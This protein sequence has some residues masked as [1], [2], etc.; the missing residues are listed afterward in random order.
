[1]MEFVI[2]GRTELYV[3]GQPV[4]LGAARQRGLLAV[5][6]YHVGEGVGADA[7]V[8]YLWPGRPGADYRRQLY[9]L[10]SRARSVLAGVGL[11]D[12]LNRASSGHG[13]R[14]VVDPE[15]IDYHRFRN[16]VG[17][18]RHAA[19]RRS[20]ELAADRLTAAVDLWRDE[21]L[22]DLDGPRVEHLRRHMRLLH[23]DAVRMLADYQLR[24]GRHEAVLA[25]LEPLVGEDTMDEALAQYWIEAQCASGRYD[26]ARSFFT[27]FRDR[28][29]RQ[30]RVD[31]AV[32]LPTA[33]RAG[34]RSEA[35]GSARGNAGG[36]RLLPADINDFT[37]HS[38]TLDILDRLTDPSGQRS[39]VVAVCGMPG[40]GKTT[41]AI[42]W[43]H[44][45][46]RRFPDGQIY[47]DARGYGPTRAA[48]PDEILGRLLEALGL[49]ADRSPTNPERRRERLSRLLTGRRALI[50][51]D[52]V[53]NSAHAEALLTTADTCVTLVT[54]RSRL[55][56]LS[57]QR[58]VRNLVI[59]PLSEDDALAFLAQLV[60]TPRAH[61]EPDAMRALAR[62]AAGLPLALRIIGEH[63][64]ERP[65]ARLADL[66]HELSTRLLADTADEELNLRSV[67]GWSY[68]RLD[69]RTAQAFRIIGLH[70][71]ATITPE[72]AAA[73]S[74]IPA[75]ECEQLLDQLARAHLINHD[76]AGRYRPHDLL[77]R[78]ATDRG[79]RQDRVE[80]RRAATDR[81][82]DWYLLSAANAATTLAAHAEPV[83]DLPSPGD[84]TPLTF[85]SSLDATR[86]AEAEREN[87]AAVTRWA[88][89]HDHHRHAWQ[90]PGVIHQILDPSGRMDDIVELN[91]IALT[92]VRADR[93]ESGEIGILNNLG[94][95]YF[96][97][98]DYDRASHYFE[99][100]LALARHSGL[101]DA[102]TVYAYNLASAHFKLGQTDT[103]LSEYMRVLR[104][105]RKVSDPAGEAATLHRLG[106]VHRRTGAVHTAIDYYGQALTIRKRLGLPRETAA[107][108][109]AL[110]AAYLQAG[111]TARAETYGQ[112]ALEL[113]VTTRDEPA[114]CDML[115]TMA[116]VRRQ[117][118]ITVQALQDARRALALADGLADSLRQGT[119]GTA[120]AG[121]L[122]AAGDT[123]AARAACR[124]AL[125]IL[126]DVIDPDARVPYQ[127]L[128]ELHRTLSGES[129]TSG[130][131]RNANGSS[132]LQQDR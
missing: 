127:R 110:A 100:A 19:S 29:R 91:R 97:R 76:T 43:A 62:I 17:A 8:E 44:T 40:S 111:Q 117:N 96:K 50:V 68:D 67:F 84:V 118:G 106:D 55:R 63:I 129:T 11:R 65:Q 123:A 38:D 86:W 98:H 88:A 79:Q 101:P 61:T 122:A 2:L 72:A 87:L 16:L 46:K 124:R 9:T 109:G 34:Y 125:A 24:L 70:P 21:P 121:A 10:V 119:A 15:S 113:Y 33:V 99:T 49:P 36:P 90:I 75:E 30:N 89:C 92:A 41:L 20:Y 74:G 14:L 1:M 71:G 48:D 18:A 5:L 60:G 42:H 108:L 102:D 3:A 93:H 131:H 95:A 13:Y 54:S 53:S 104:A 128:A 103:S 12:G 77:R 7:L 35:A 83:P 80:D 114:E 82:L 130:V 47:L 64:V 45:R 105:C 22:A 57:I 52:N 66:A 23:L 56:T 126:A 6:L 27:A 73:L 31:P 58:A 115:V 85:A 81:L 120:L 78:Y 28:Y 4:S 94:A 37:G 132:R 107:T 39:T 116:D 69:A 26:N 25:R 112:R 51:I 59:E 32:R